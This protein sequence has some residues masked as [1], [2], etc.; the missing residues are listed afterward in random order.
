MWMLGRGN[1]LAAAR[2][3]C[4]VGAA[5]AL[6]S[7]QAADF[8]FNTPKMDVTT[9]IPP[10]PDQ[11]ARK[12]RTLQPI[13][14]AD[15][16]DASGACAGGDATAAVPSEQ[17]SDPQA[18][19]SP[20]PPPRGI[21]LEMTECEVVRAAGRPAEVQ[22]SADQRGE[23]AVTMIYASP[24]RPIY[25][26]VAGRLKTVERGAEPPPEPAARKP[27]PRKPPPRRAS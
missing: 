6:A 15:L 10:D 27:A 23:R 1:S 11:F 22:V 25:R 17:A 19:P 12:Q 14:P 7:C 13:G 5:F 3:A 18:A 9:I 16:V 26:F 8:Q 2:A 21:A 20:P 4:V 24:E